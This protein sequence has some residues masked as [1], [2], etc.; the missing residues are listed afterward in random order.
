MFRFAAGA[1]F[2]CR[3][4]FAKPDLSGMLL[5]APLAALRL[6]GDAFLCALLSSRR[7]N[8]TVQSVA[9]PRALRVSTTLA[10]TLSGGSRA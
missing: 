8:V 2:F 4:N 1:L 7:P 9:A 6:S 3:H 10:L 5:C